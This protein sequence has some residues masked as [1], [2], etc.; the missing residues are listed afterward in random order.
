[1]IYFTSDL[2][3]GHEAVIRMQKRPFTNAEWSSYL[4][5]ALSDAFMAEKPLWKH[6]AVWTYSLGWEL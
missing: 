5:N 1:M 2:H 4:I 6:Y 3:L